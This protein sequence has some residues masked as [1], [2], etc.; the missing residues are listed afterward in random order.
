M[1]FLLFILLF[2]VACSDN[3]LHSETKQLS[4]E[5][6]YIEAQNNPPVILTDYAQPYS[7]T[8]LIGSTI[9]FHAKINPPGAEI[10]HCYWLIESNK[11]PCLL[12][13]KNLY[14]FDTIGLY[15]IK[16]YVLDIF[17]DTLS[18]NMSMRVSSKPVC[19]NLSLEFFQGSPIFKWNC[20]DSDPSSTLTYKFILKTKDETKTI[21]LKE[22]SL[23]LGYS[24]P[25]DYWEVNLTAENSYGFKADLDSIFIDEPEIIDESEDP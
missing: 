10:K 16:L 22:D 8:I 17:G 21:S 9:F 14:T 25:S 5:R 24:L 4:I 15:P 7:D 19:D 1:P 13:K 2:L 12:Q 6:I 3:L 23:Q 11:L 18:V 20:Q